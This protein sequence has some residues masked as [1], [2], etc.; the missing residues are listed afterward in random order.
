MAALRNWE[1]GNFLNILSGDY[2]NID[3]KYYYQIREPKEHKF[4]K[5]KNVLES[6]GI[7]NIIE[8]H[9]IENNKEN[10]FYFIYQLSDLRFLEFGSFLKL[11]FVGLMK[12]NKNVKVVFLNEHESESEESY[13]LLS[14][15]TTRMGLDQDQFYFINN[16]SNLSEYK[17]KHNGVNTHSIRFLP[18]YYSKHIFKT[19]I[20]LITDKPNLFLCHNKR[21]KPHR[22]ATLLELKKN[23]ILENTDWSFLL[24]DDPNRDYYQFFKNLY[25]NDEV[26]TLLPEISYFNNLTG[27]KSNYEKTHSNDNLENDFIY[28]NTFENSYINIVTETYFESNII[29]ITEKSFKPFYFYQLPIFVSTCGHVKKLKEIYGF[30][31]F[32][33]FIDHTYDNINDDKKRFKLIIDQIKKLDKINVKK[34]YSDN[35]ERLIKNKRI[36]MNIT[37]DNW[38]VH[39]FNKLINNG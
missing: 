25:N 37:N 38:D 1:M 30:D 15:S 27:K 35:V 28:P 20:D 10:Y 39:Y 8:R 21:I 23:S 29:H 13:R 19:E 34:F 22:Y 14:E 6:I 24:N 12:N 36:I 4:N 11:D 17:I 5:I 31:I 3:E 32:E 7:N 2:E 26:T 18:S 33:D 16:N 9:S